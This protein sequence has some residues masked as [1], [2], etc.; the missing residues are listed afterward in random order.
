MSRPAQLPPVNLHGLDPKWSK[1]VDF[2]DRDGISRGVHVLDTG[3]DRAA[4]LTLVCV[5]GNPTWSYLWR[6][7]LRQAPI[8]IRV[9]AVD[10]LGMGYSERLSSDRVLE[11]RVD[12]LTRVVAA[13]EVTTPIVSLAHDWG[14]PISLGWVENEIRS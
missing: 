13:L 12:D 9:I 11:Q 14:G 6:N 5:H 2:T 1:I 3:T 7:F 10:Q 8:N 4:E